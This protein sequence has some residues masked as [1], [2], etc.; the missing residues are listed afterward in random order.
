MKCRITRIILIIAF[1]LSFITFAG[2]EETG[3]PRWAYVAVKQVAAAGL[4]E[5]YENAS[6]AD[7][8]KIYSMSREELA[9]L[10]IKAQQSKEEA[11][12]AKKKNIAKL[13]REFAIE[14][15]KVNQ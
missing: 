2:A 12:G 5:G 14:I 15:E 9:K 3:V 8:E 10:V 1:S 13:S 4:I 7:L 11:S 6:D